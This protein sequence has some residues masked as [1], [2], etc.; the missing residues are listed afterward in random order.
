MNLRY[1]N[2]FYSFGTNPNTFGL[3]LSPYHSN[4]RMILERVR[5]KSFE[6]KIVWSFDQGA[7]IKFNFCKYV[8][9]GDIQK[10]KIKMELL[11][12]SGVRREGGEE[13]ERK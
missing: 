6:K 8:S 3:M 2:R 5:K 12:S 1:G 7:Q 13:R 11:L 10:L 9:A 4:N